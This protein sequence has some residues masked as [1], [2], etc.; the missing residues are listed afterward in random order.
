[1]LCELPG[2][3]Y[4]Q[5]ISRILLIMISMR[6]LSSFIEFSAALLMLY[7]KNIESAIRINA[8]LGLVGPFILII[9]T[10]L[11]L[12]EISDQLNFKNLILICLGVL[13]ILL[14]TR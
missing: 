10:F 12:I 14:G 8:V 5:N 9:V 7:L 13:L 6:L 3:L 2:G 4:M 1:M 11:G